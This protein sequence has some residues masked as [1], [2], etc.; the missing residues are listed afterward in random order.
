MLVTLIGMGLATA[1]TL[2]R[3]GAQ[4]GRE[5]ELLFIGNPYRQAIESV[6]ELDPAQPRLPRSIDNLLV[7][8]RR[9]KSWH[10]RRAYGAP[11]TGG[12][13]ALIH[14]P[15]TQ[16]IVGVMRQAMGVPSRSQDSCPRTHRT[17]AQPAMPAGVLSLASRSA[18]GEA[19][20]MTCPS[21]S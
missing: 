5:A 12:E 2:W 16:G 20:T 6:Y 17:P 10:L 7:G 8:N 13:L 18:A 1:G 19:V 15:D 9:P 21:T 11:L 14:A 3:T 4:R